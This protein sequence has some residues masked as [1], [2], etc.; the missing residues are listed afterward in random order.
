MKIFSSNHC[1]SRQ[2]G[3]TLIEV[4]VGMVICAILGGGVIT[5]MYQIGSV[6][7]INNARMTAVKQVENAVHYLNRDMQMAQKVESDGQDYWLRLSWTTWDNYQNVQVKY[8]YNTNQK[9]LSRYYSV[10]GGVAAINIVGKY[11]TSVLATK[12]N[13]GATPPEKAWTLQLTA[14]APFKLKQAAETR[15]IKIIPRPGS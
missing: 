2:S 5:A 3:F 8:I 6:N 9:T 4:L 1:F 7:G 13:A 12:P 14:D 11:V 10:D 15:Q